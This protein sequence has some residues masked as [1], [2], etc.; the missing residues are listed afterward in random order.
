MDLQRDYS[1][2]VSPPERTGHTAFLKKLEE[3]GIHSYG[4]KGIKRFEDR[5]ERVICRAYRKVEKAGRSFTDLG[6]STREGPVAEETEDL[7]KHHY[8]Q[9]FEFFRNFLDRRFMAYSM[10]FFGESPEQAKSSPKT[11]EEA[12]TAKFELMC[13]RA[14][15]KGNEHIFNIGCGFGSLE[16]FLLQRYPQMHI[17]GITPSKVQSRYLRERMNNPEDPLGQGRFAL[18]VG[19][20]GQVSLKELAGPYDLVFSVGTLEHFKNMFAAFERMAAILKPGGR[21]FHHI[22][23]SRYAIPRYSDSKKSRLKDYFPGAR[24]FPFSELA[25]QKD[26]F[27]LRGSWFVNGMNYWRTL[28]EWHRRFWERME[29]VYFP[30]LG[31][32][33]IQYWNDYFSISKAMF[34]PISGTVLGNG[35]YYFVKK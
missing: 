28:D 25:E 24:V 14:E 22:I 16:T 35:Q 2:T 13:Q 1:G 6:V 4:S 9:P 32:E 15:I 27:D 7:M 19:G 33:G 21:A 31:R 3:A 30:L 8:D 17:V 20:F 23:S 5:L 26:Y 18:V 12:Q 34:A 11:L 29:T 10:A